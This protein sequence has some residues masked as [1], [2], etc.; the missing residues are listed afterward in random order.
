MKKKLYTREDVEKIIALGRQ[1]GFVTYDQVNDLLP[2]GVSSSEDIDRIFDIL[3]DEDIQIVENEDEAAA[4]A[5]KD[6]AKREE[7]SLLEAAAEEQVYPLDDPV[8]M[9]LKQMGSIALLSREEEIELARKIEEA[10]LKFKTAVLATRFA[11]N[12]V[13]TVAADVLAGTLNPEEVVKG[14]IDANPQNII[15]RFRRIYQRL[16]RTRSRKKQ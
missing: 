11:Y 6:A 14:E 16:K 1:K 4:E 13:M 8:K 5:E 12:E 15:R 9:Y 3:G 7:E 10:E 2:D